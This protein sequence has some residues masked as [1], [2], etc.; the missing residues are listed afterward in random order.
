MSHVIVTPGKKWIPTAKVVAE[1]TTN[2]DAEINGYYRRGPG[3]VSFYE[4]DGKLFAFLVTNKHRERFFVTASDS[5]DGV[6]YMFSTCSITQR[7]LGIDGLGH[8]DTKTLEDEIVDALD[9]HTAR[10]ALS[11]QGVN[12]EQFVEMA[13]RKETSAVAL[14]AFYEA[15]LTTELEGIESDGYLLATTLGRFMLREAGYDQVDGAWTPTVQA[16]A[17]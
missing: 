14:K 11:K 17:A 2:G 13:N 12:F 3:G 4:L 15:G 1:S 16:A 7:K 6:R 10:K 8:I 9:A 5:S